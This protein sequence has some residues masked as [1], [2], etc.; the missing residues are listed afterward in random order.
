MKKTRKFGKKIYRHKS[1][2]KSKRDAEKIAKNYRTGSKSK[3][4][5]VVKTDGKHCV[6]TRG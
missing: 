2:H 1:C 6:F 3:G 5:R 4:A